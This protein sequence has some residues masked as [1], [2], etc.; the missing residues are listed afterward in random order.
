MRGLLYVKGYSALYL[1]MYS[2]PINADVP[3]EEGLPC[4]VTSMPVEPSMRMPPIAVVAVVSMAA[5]LNAPLDAPAPQV[6]VTAR[7][8][9]RAKSSGST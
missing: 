7:K 2:L 6:A 1:V 8:S 5:G 4:E 3:S 9:G